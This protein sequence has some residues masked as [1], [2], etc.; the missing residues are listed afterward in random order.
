MLKNLLGEAERTKKL[1][2]TLWSAHY[3]WRAREG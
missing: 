1:K 2:F 3:F